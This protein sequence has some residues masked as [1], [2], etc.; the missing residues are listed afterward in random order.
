M[1][2]HPLTQISTYCRHRGV[3]LRHLAFFSGVLF[4]LWASYSTLFSH[5]SLITLPWRIHVDV[6]YP[7]TSTTTPEEWRS[8]AEQV[9]AAFVHAYN[10]Y[11]E[12]AWKWDELKPLTSRGQNKYGVIDTSVEFDIEGRMSAASMDGA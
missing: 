7:I 4:F 5:Q 1:H 10:G 2:A 11:E 12:H 8:R 6:N 9:K 3:T